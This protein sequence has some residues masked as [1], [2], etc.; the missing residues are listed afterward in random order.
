MDVRLVGRTVTV[1]LNG[2]KV[3][4]KQQIEGF[5]AVVVDPNEAEAGPLILQGDHR[6]VEFRKIVVIPLV[7]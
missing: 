4:D 7:R 1:V 6:P 2:E 5:T 3:I